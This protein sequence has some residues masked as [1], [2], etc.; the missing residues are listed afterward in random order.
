MIPDFD[1]RGTI[2][3][4]TRQDPVKVAPHIYRVLFE[5]DRVRVLD[6]R[7]QPGAK[8]PMHSH[9]AVVAYLLAGGKL[10]VTT[11][12]DG[13]TTVLESKAGSVLWLEPQTHS[14]ENIGSTETKDVV[15]ELK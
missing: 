7:M 8:S 11:Y 12:P 15:I 3:A 2:M 1:I 14:V 10:R 5:N 9:P 6:V 4:V 13:K